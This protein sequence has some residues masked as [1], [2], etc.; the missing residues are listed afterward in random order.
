VVDCPACDQSFLLPTRKGDA[1]A[2]RSQEPLGLASSEPLRLPNPEADDDTH[3]RDVRLSTTGAI[4][5]G[6]TLVF[7]LGLVT[8]LGDSYFG[9]LFG[10]RGWVPYAISYLALWC[11]VLLAAKYLRLRRRLGVLE[12]DLL[13]RQLSSEITPDNVQGFITYL[14]RLPG[15][16]S[17]DFLFQRIRRA[18]NHFHARANVAETVDQLRLDAERDESIVDSGYTMLRVFIWA[19]PIL[20]FIGT[21][22]GIGASV[23]GFSESVSAASN[24]DVMKDAI[25][26]VTSGLGIA[27]DTTLLALVMSI[28]IMV[29]TSSLQKTEEDY[30]AL[31]DDYCQSHL[32]GRLA[33]GQSGG[34][35]AREDEWLN[36][37]ADRLADR[38]VRALDRRLSGTD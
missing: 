10:A 37:A 17:Q 1:A 6:L 2:S 19:I 13:P 5:G 31:V 25:G 20:G 18:L 11:G 15:R 14:S 27:F 8:P 35:S 24:L 4:A 21:V 23:A 28:F 7:Y 33:D 16:Y 34:H 3:S 12:L 9:Q 36:A 32:V 30:L 38:V 29:P 26:V 22:L